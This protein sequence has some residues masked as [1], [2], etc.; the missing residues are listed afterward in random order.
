MVDYEKAVAELD[1]TIARRKAA[2]AR[3]RAGGD[4]P[5]APD[6]SAAQAGKRGT[7]DERRLVKLLKQVQRRKFKLVKDRRRREGKKE[8]AAAT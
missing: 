1:G 6:S 4:L 7:V 5:A 8:E 2:L 3:F